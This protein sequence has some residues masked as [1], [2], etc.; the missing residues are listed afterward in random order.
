MDEWLVERVLL[1]TECIPPGRV[2]SY[3]DL[4][5]LVGT[6]P[7]QVGAILARFGSSVPWWRVTNASG[8][9]RPTCWSRPLRTGRTRGSGSS[10]TAGAARCAA[11]GPTCVNSPRCSSGPRRSKGSRE[12]E[13][14]PSGSGGSRE[15]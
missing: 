15:G 14:R 3:G 12:G 1:A 4:A 2:A 10:P 9:S 11:I 5:R 13:G 6:G 8:S 7:R